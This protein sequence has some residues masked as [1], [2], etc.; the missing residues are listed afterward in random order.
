[1]K[2]VEGRRCNFRKEGVKSSATEMTEKKTN[3]LEGLPKASIV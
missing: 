1:V 2:V 3:L